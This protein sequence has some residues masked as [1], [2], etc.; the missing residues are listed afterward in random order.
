MERPIRILLIEDLQ[1]DAEFIVRA[2]TRAGMNFSTER[3]ETEGGL[4][5]A[6]ERFDPDIV[7]SDFSLP[8]FDGVGA[9]DIVRRERPRV[10]FVF[11]SGTIGEDRA[12][13][14]LKRGATDYVLKTNLSRLAPAVTRALAEAALDTARRN[15]VDQLRDNE[16]RLRDII[17]TSQD[18]IWELD[19]EGRFTFSSGAALPILGYASE[20]IIGRSF[21]E[22]LHPD[23]SWRMP[24][25]LPRLDAG[26]MSI[27]GVTARWVHRDGTHRWL[28]RSAIVLVDASGALRGYRGTERD[29][30]QRLDHEAR[31]ARLNR[32]HTLLSSVNATVARSTD[33][34]QLLQDVCRL[35]VERGGYVRAI[36]AL[37]NPGTPTVR[38]VAWNSVLTDSLRTLAFPLASPAN[39][40]ISLCAAA[41]GAQR[42]AVCNDLATSGPTAIRHRQELYNIGVRAVAVLP[43]V[44]DTRVIGT[45]SFESREPD[46]FDTEE[47]GLLVDVATEVGFSLQYFQKE[48]AVH[49]LSWFDSLTQL[50]KRDLFCERLT[51]VL[52]SQSSD[53]VAAVLIVDIERIGFVNDTLGR[54]AGDQLL[55]MAAQRLKTQLGNP[56]RLAHFGAGVFAIAFSELD[57][58]S[59]ELDRAR[60]QVRAVFND[61]FPLDDREIDLSIRTGLAHYPKDGEDAT[62][63]VQNAEAA[64]RRGKETGTED[65]DYTVTINSQL[66]ER[67][68][69][70]QKLNRAL[71]AQQFILHYQPIV[72]IERGRIVSAEAL[73]RWHDPDRGLVPPGQFIPLLE[74]S[75]QIVEVG[76]WVFEQVARD[77]LRLQKAGIENLRM[78]VNISPLQLRRPDF[79]ERIVETV[80]EN[81]GGDTGLEIEITESMLMQDLEASIEKLTLLRHTGVRVSI[82]DFGT[83][84]SSL[85]L[86]ARL[87]ID[88]LK[89]DRSFI[90]RLAEDP[91]SMTVISTIIGLARSFRLRAV[92][93]GVET[94]EQLKL[95]RLMKCDMAQGYLFGHPMT[96]EDLQAQVLG[97]AG[98]LARSRQA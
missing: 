49:F 48:D 69:V 55:R 73:L 74:E 97:G 33:R 94:E 67:L 84:Y 3:V 63:L 68:M 71:E 45:I 62:S 29:L 20:D 60:D 46:V 17:D 64:L 22:L 27:S 79:V 13:E 76:Q 34:A 65:F 57:A 28:E 24:E 56:D 15:A 47:L 2:L 70:S 37:L 83:G 59:A 4:L 66:A 32:I 10:P 9:L 54:E 14:A 12:I 41:I 78:A 58:S 36:I 87:P 43:M 42:A 90:N 80:V 6:L 96:I 52:N 26:E 18:W 95:L 7:L 23:D 16:Q 11:V 40:G 8:E 93:E 38:P 35:A 5:E 82:D 19:S 85:A 31:I 88:C 61:P 72:D 39:D 89:I 77:S 81:E 30:T 92:A 86:L 98:T 25:L 44:V 50:A 21:A 91:A 53:S 1:A 75:G 51:R